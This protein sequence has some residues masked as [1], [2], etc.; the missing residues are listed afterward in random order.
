MTYETD[1][2]GVIVDSNQEPIRMRFLRTRYNY[3]ADVVSRETGLRCE[4]ETMAQQQFKD[5]CDINTIVRQFGITGQLPTNLRMPLNEAFVDV[6]DYQSAL[7][8]IMESEAAFM[9][10]PAEI[11][12]TFQNDP[13]RFVDYVSDEKNVEQCRKWGLAMPA[14]VAPERVPLDVRVVDGTALKSS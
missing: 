2:D 10:M 11:R 7:N 9:Q 14:E 5:E 13:Q 3:D 6:M 8:Q 4:D 12:E 1:D